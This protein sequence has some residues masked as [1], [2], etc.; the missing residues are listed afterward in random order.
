MPRGASGRRGT[1]E[2]KGRHGEGGGRRPGLGS[3]ARCRAPCLTPA[4]DPYV[5]DTSR[6]RAHSKYRRRRSAQVGAQLA[7]KL[8]GGS[9]LPPGAPAV[10]V[11]TGTDFRQRYGARQGPLPVAHLSLKPGCPGASRL[12]GRL[13]GPRWAARSPPGRPPGGEAA[14]PWTSP[15]SWRKTST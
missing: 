11:A 2:R 9:A 8:A 10:A 4:P 15:G 14:R 5:G 6:T 1:Q 13:R 12:P 7:R 3:E